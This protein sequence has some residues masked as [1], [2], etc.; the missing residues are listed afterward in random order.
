MSCLLPVGVS[1]G[2]LLSPFDMVLEVFNI[3]LDF[4]YDK[5]FWVHVVHLSKKSWFFLLEENVLRKQTLGTRGTH[6]YWGA[7]CF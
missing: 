6:C 2:C 5:V 1:S 4:S 3:F 7:H